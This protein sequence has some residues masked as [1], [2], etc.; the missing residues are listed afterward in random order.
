MPM[1]TR[2]S[3]D[4]FDGSATHDQMRWVDN[5]LAAHLLAAAGDTAA[6]L[7][8]IRRRPRSLEIIDQGYMTVEH[9]REEG[10][11]AAAMADTAGALAVY[12]QYLELRVP[13]SDH[14]PW[15]AERDSVAALTRR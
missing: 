3:T 8:A 6:A 2:G 1:P 15:R 10:R 12:R 9:L 13:A 11:Y 7:G 5:Y 4:A 14:P